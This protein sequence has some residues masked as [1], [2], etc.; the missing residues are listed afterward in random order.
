[1][2][3]AGER[4]CA[5]AL[6]RGQPARRADGMP[7]WR[8]GGWAASSRQRV[9]AGPAEAWLHGQSEWEQLTGGIASLPGLSAQEARLQTQRGATASS[10]RDYKNTNSSSRGWL[11]SRTTCLGE[12]LPWSR[13]AGSSSLQQLASELETMQRRPAPYASARPNSRPVSTIWRRRSR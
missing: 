8:H 10:E 5:S 1:M 7:A 9:A 3:R 11:P 2:R 12:R 4:P 6:S 13:A